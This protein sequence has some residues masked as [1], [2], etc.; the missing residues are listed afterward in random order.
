MM[1]DWFEHD[2]GSNIPI[3]SIDSHAEV[4]VDAMLGDC[5]LKLLLLES[6]VAPRG[7]SPGNLHDWVKERSTNIFLFDRYRELSA[8][9]KLPEG[10][11]KV[12]G[13]AHA[14]PTSFEAWIGRVW[15]ESGKD[16]QA[17]AAKVMPALGLRTEIK[18]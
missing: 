12:T 9:D 11:P 17:T 5:V 14:D 16:L 15:N 13:Q 1:H 7:D 3:Q 2:N 8:A 4:S 10:L 18:G 6:A